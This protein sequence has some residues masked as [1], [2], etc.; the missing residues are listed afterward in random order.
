MFRPI[1][2]LE[3]RKKNHLEPNIY[4]QMLLVFIP[5]RCLHTEMMMRNLKPAIKG[6]ILCVFQTFTAKPH[7][8][9]SSGSVDESVM[10]ETWS[11]SSCWESW[12]EA[13]FGYFISTLKTRTFRYKKSEFTR[14]YSL[15]DGYEELESTGCDIKKREIFS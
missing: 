10:M 6:V 3:L 12:R 5:L 1:W 7:A 15:C 2:D 11:H 13:V 4:K 14:Y 9:G 8:G